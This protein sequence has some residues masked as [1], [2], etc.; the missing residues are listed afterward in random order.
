MTLPRECH[1]QHT[2]LNDC[3]D[4]YSVVGG[5]AVKCLEQTLLYLKI[6]LPIKNAADHERLHSLEIR[7]AV[8]VKSA[9][10]KI[11]GRLARH[12]VFL[13]EFPARSILEDR[14]EK[15]LLF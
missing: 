11:C 14:K 15:K 5:V 6:L 1:E 3:D 12:L 13:R 7:P 8:R 9:F 10:S 2:Q 4:L